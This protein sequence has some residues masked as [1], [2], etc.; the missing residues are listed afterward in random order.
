MTLN[1]PN[2]KMNIKMHTPLYT[3]KNVIIKKYRNT[4]I[5]NYK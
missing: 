5:K 2:I 1:P 3:T 4:D